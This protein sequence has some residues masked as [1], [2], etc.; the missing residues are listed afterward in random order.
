M[1]Q[2]E[3]I[4]ELAERFGAAESQIRRDHL[5]SHLLGSL[6][7]SIASRLIFIGGTALNRSFVPHGRL[8]EDIDLVAIGSR[9]DVVREV[10][11]TLARGVRREY[12]RVRWEPPLTA[13][14]DVE[15]AVLVTEDG[16]RVRVQLLDPVGLPAWPTQLQTLEQR[17]RDAPPARLLLPTLSAFVA[18]KTVAW[19]DR[20]A[21]RDL[22][23]LWQLAGIGAIGEE[24]A[25][26]Y[27][28]LGPSGALPAKQQLR[29]LPDEAQWRR[30]L[31]GQTRLT[32]TASAAS[33]RV[34]EAW[35]RLR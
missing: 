25:S 8:S 31:S 12:P 35:S 9:A 16:L 6:S 20:A 22:F 32:V 11:R 21:P 10:E 15:P 34:V 7:A 2:Q 29:R 1:L 17:Y 27:R 4:R 33:V 28:R 26:L 14:R 3:E 30:E 23:D 19:V 5:I 18:A 24:A 13:V